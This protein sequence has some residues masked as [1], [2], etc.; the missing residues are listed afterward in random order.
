MHLRK[1]H[2]KGVL[3][4]KNKFCKTTF[5]Q[6]NSVH[7]QVVQEANLGKQCFEGFFRK[8]LKKLFNIN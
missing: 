3:Y 8:I 4:L 7:K 2:F 5:L 1:M 6:N